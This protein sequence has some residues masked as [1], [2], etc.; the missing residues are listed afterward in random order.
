MRIMARTLR[1]EVRPVVVHRKIRMLTSAEHHNTSRPPMG[2]LFARIAAMEREPGILGATIFATQPWMD[3][4]EL[5]WSALHAGHLGCCQPT[6][7]HVGMRL[8]RRRGRPVMVNVTVAFTTLI[9]ADDQPSH[10]HGYG[11]ITA[12]VARRIAADGTWRSL[13]TDPVSG[14][15]LDV[16]RERYLP[17]PELAEHVIVRDKTCRF[18]TCTHPAET[19]DL[20]HSTP[21]AQGGQTTAGNLGP[22]HRPHHNDHTH[23][24]WRLDQTEPGRFI[25]TAPTGHR[26]EVD[27]EIV[28][29]L[30]QPPPADAEKPTDPDPPPF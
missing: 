8:G 18:P 29:L 20:D 6:C 27:P 28:G 5:G 10:L 11:P 15:V 3:V 22:V 2:E 23:H 17:P 16:G 26:Y 7:G 4:A 12:A 25:W 30:P 9:G 14:A 21:W 13:L 1:G 24:G 19:C